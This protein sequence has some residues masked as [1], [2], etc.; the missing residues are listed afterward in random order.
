M[1]LTATRCMWAATFLPLVEFSSP[2]VLALIKLHKCSSQHACQSSKLAEYCQCA[3][4]KHYLSI[5][6]N[7][8][9]D[10]SAA[11]LQLAMQLLQTCCCYCGWL[12]ALN[13]GCNCLQIR[14]RTPQQRTCSWPCSCRRRRSRSTSASLQRSMRSSSGRQIRQAAPRHQ[15]RLPVGA[16]ATQGGDQHMAVTGLLPLHLKPY[17]PVKAVLPDRRL[18]VVRKSQWRSLNRPEGALQRAQCIRAGAGMDHMS[19]EDTAS[20]LKQ[21]AGTAETVH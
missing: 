2:V 13:D 3:M 8:E 16:L 17:C 21:A 7:A 6:G 12:P 19:P 18:H 10:T 4:S 14:Q 20:Q 11:D 15:I 5:F 9:P 1:P